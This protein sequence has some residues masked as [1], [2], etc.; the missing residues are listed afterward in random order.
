MMRVLRE[1]TVIDIHGDV[2]KIQEGIDREGSWYRVSNILND[3]VAFARNMTIPF[4]DYCCEMVRA[5]FLDVV[6]DE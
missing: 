4:E 5:T 1:M 2:F 3:T 6:H